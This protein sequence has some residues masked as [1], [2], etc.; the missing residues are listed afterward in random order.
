MADGAQL[1]AVSLGARGCYYATRKAR[2]YVRGWPV[3]AVDTTGAGDTFHG[4]YIF[5]LLK[6]WGLAER[7]KF[8]S[9]VAAIKC[10]RLGAQSSPRFEEVNEF[11]KSRGVNL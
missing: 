4:A 1:V 5:G 6:G 2:N 8:A 3:E 7:L 10:T 11:L 9:A